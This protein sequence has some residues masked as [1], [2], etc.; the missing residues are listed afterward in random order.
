VGMAKGMNMTMGVG[1]DMQSPCIGLGQREQR[2]S[3]PSCG[4]GGDVD[5][6][7]ETGV[8]SEDIKAGFDMRIGLRL[9]LGVQDGCIHTIV[10]HTHKQC[11]RMGR[12]YHD[13]ER[14]DESFAMRVGRVPPPAQV[15]G[16][17][18]GGCAEAGGRCLGPREERLQEYVVQTSDSLHMCSSSMDLA[19]RCQSALLVRSRLNAAASNG[20]LWLKEPHTGDEIAQTRKGCTLIARHDVL[21]MREGTFTGYWVIWVIE[22]DDVGGTS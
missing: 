15:A 22:E 11:K 12:A 7:F 10:N 2:D 16:H 18:H 9:N 20:G 13:G 1:A 3:C 8:G 17:R 4:A 5:E 14:I 19:K 6:R 21:L